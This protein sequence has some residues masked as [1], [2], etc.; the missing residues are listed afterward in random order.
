[1]GVYGMA[2]NLLLEALEKVP[3][4]ASYHYHLGV[5]YQKQNNSAAARKQL[6]RAL[7]LNPNAPGAA[8][9]RKTLEQLG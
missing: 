9:I 6:Q 1:M 5:V 8:K 7:E 3:D 2:A 4:N